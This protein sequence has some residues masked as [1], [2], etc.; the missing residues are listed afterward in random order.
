MIA[1]TLLRLLLCAVAVWFGT[2]LHLVFW[3]TGFLALP[4]LIEPGRL[5]A[6]LL[7][8]A[9][10]LGWALGSCNQTH[11]LWKV[12][13]LPLWVVILSPVGT[14]LVFALA[15]RIFRN[16][17]QKQR[18]FL[19]A[20]F[21]S[22]IWTTYEFLR[23]R[24]SIHGTIDNLAYT[25]MDFPAMLQIA[26]VTGLCGIGFVLFFSQGLL[27]AGK[28]MAAL[29]VIVLVAGAGAL[30]LQQDPGTPVMV[31]LVA[32]DAK[33]PLETKLDRY[34]DTAR[35]LIAQG[36]RVVLLPEKIVRID[37]AQLT[38]IDQRFL[39]LPALT[40]VGI[41]RWT[42]KDKRNESRVY[43]NGSV[44]AVY[45]KQHMLPPFESH[46]LVGTERVTWREPAGIY[47]TA[48]CKDMGFPSLAR[49]YGNDGAALML[50]P[51][52]DFEEDRWYSDRVAMLRG[53]ESGFSVVRAPRA[54]NLIAADAFGRV[55]AEKPSYAEEFST[56]L[57]KVPVRHLNT[58]YN[59]LGDWF[60]FTVSG[61]LAVLWLRVR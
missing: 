28:P 19:A 10:F 44:R 35:G 20:F 13:G 27:A 61:L 31:G 21:F 49:G 52:F 43:E 36:A 7:W 46:L 60:C 2:G 29:L 24:I 1:E 18:R 54:G 48:I 59:A 55:L 16:Y 34:A 53:V 22:A 23:F 11:Y 57:V 33:L 6:R 41:E 38:G 47:G 8:C 15:V 14:G 30:R 4:V 17:H 3:V 56:L 5:P 40:V 42:A 32:S 26:S 37:D 45:E 51:A 25:Q 9:A 58:L 12:L 50:I 39:P